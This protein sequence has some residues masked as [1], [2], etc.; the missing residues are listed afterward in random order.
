MVLFYC[1]YSSCQLIKKPLRL[2]EAA[3]FRLKRKL[4]NFFKVSIYDFFIT[5]TSLSLTSICSGISTG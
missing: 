4:F 3:F 5:I 1:L 2:L